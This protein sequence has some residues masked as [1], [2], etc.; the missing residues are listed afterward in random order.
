MISSYLNDKKFIRK[1]KKIIYYYIYYFTNNNRPDISR[2][3]IQFTE[4]KESPFAIALSMG[5]HIFYN[6]WISWNLCFNCYLITNTILFSLS[7]H[8]HFDFET[9]T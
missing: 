1:I 6:N 4:Y 5:Q 9:A 8:H 7:S 3:I 2:P